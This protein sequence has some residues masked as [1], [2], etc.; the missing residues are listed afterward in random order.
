MKLKVGEVFTA[1][2]G[3]TYDVVVSVEKINGEEKYW[4]D[5]WQIKDLTY[6]DK[7]QGK[8]VVWSEAL[9]DNEGAKIDVEC[10]TE[11]ELDS[12]Q[13]G[14]GDQFKILGMMNKDFGLNDKF[15]LVPI[16]KATRKWVKR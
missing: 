4:Y 11:S 3:E 10:M 2:A 14:V 15:H 12:L 5:I 16:E 13:F 6:W 8:Y 1:N 9:S 7:E